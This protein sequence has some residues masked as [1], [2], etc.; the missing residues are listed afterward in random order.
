[1]MDSILRVLAVSLIGCLSLTSYY[2]R[3][4]ADVFEGKYDEL[5]EAARMNDFD[6]DGEAWVLVFLGE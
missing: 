6:G 2:Y 1:M 5:T 3:E 4:R